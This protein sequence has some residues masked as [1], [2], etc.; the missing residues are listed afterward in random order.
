MD[1]KFWSYSGI[2][3]NN[4]NEQITDTH[5]TDKISKTLYYIKEA[6]SLYDSTDDNEQN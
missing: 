4:K 5:N 6:E 1:K 2:L 3:H